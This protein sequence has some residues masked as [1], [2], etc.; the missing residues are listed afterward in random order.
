[1]KTRIISAAVGIPILIAVLFFYNTITL[2]IAIAL[3][4][5][6]GVYEFL[7]STKYVT[8][9]AVLV[10]SM[11]FAA[12][13][14]FTNI[15]MLKEKRI[16]IIM[17]YIVAMIVILFTR[18]STLKFEQIA[19]AF[20]VSVL[21]PFALSSFVFI[22]DAYPVGVY[23]ILL[24]FLCGWITD[25]GAYFIG[26]VFGKHKLAANISPKKTIEGAVGGVVFCVIFNV[27]FTY[28]FTV[29]T[30]DSFHLEANLVA[31]LVIT[32][33]ASVIGIFGDLFASIVKRQT[34]IKDF[35]NVIP[36]HGG[37]IDRFDSVLFIAPFVYVMCDFM[38]ILSVA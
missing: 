20:T 27:A 3:V 7:H 23:Y 21:I 1:M 15:P 8:N 37:I 5:L 14:P 38:P 2:N 26:R 9:P 4:C 25:A 28:V 24:I 11:V 6:I 36:G 17:I 30:E 32:F 13:I 35:G 22:R 29:I 10:F 18:H 16:L 34:G 12:V 19:V 33:A 31:L